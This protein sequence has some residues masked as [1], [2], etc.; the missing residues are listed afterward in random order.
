MQRREAAYVIAALATALGQAP[1][2]ADDDPARFGL[3][4]NARAIGLRAAPTSAAPPVE[5]A[6]RFSQSS[7]ALRAGWTA[8][9]AVGPM[10]WLKPLEEDSEMTLRLGGR[11]AAMLGAT[12]SPG[13]T[14]T[15][16]LPRGL[17]LG[18]QYR[19]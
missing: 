14:S 1:A 9:G 6:F 2:I 4:L 11:P 8:F 13:T 7:S 18:I 17:N 5:S 3:K 12:G 10:R 19:F 15:P 16:G